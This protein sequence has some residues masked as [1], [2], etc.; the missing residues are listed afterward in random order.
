MGS[1]SWYR[2]ISYEKSES[3]NYSL[4]GLDFNK[5]RVKYLHGYLEKDS[6]NFNRFLT[7]RGIELTDKKSIIFGISE[8]VI[9][10]GLNRHL[11]FSYLN[12][13]SSHLEIELN[14]RTN[15]IGTGNGN[16]IWQLSFDYFSKYNIRLSLNYLI[17]E[18]VLD[19]EQILEG[20]SDGSGY[21]FKIAV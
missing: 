14:D 10:S 7:A 8:I 1:K 5:I 17:D 21:S 16:G 11:D 19:K 4:L 12:P 6:I 15:M 9:Y 20:K 18:F 13:M 2:I 3:Y